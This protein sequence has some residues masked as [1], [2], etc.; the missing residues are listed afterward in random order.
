M[1]KTKMNC[2]KSFSY[3]LEKLPWRAVDDLESRDW[4]VVHSSKSMEKEF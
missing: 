4:R 1:R 2:D 3:F